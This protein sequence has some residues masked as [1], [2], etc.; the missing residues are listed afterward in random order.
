MDCIMK[1]KDYCMVSMVVIE[2]KEDGHGGRDCGLI[3][4]VR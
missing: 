4:G 3:L 1:L 2:I